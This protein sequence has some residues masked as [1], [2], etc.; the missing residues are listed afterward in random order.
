MHSGS[1]SGGPYLSKQD[2]YVDLAY[3]E[4][5]SIFV[6]G[7]GDIKRENLVR[8]AKLN[9]FSNR[10]LQRGEYYT[11]FT[12]SITN[13]FIFG[14][15][16]VTIVSVSSDVLKTN[17]TLSELFSSAFR[18]QIH[19][20]KFGPENETHFPNARVEDKQDWKAL[21]IGDSVYYASNS[22]DYKLYVVSSVDKENVL[23]AATN[24][25]EKN[26]QTQM[27][28]YFFIKGPEFNGL[29]GG[30]AVVAELIDSYNSTVYEDGKV[31]GVSRGYYLVETKSGFHVLPALKLKKKNK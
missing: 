5:K 2:Q 15:I 26:I 28:G 7:I 3:G 29:K 4:S 14:F 17:D 23:L 11:N 24:S 18:K 9:M 13:Q 6:F 12:T 16:H 27:K 10:P 20:D 8:S 31:L 1:V 21:F 22:R 19:S 25:G 30:D